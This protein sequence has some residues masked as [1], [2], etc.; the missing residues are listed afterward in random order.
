MAQKS[1]EELRAHKNEKPCIRK[2]FTVQIMRF[3]RLPVCI[4]VGRICH[5]WCNFYPGY[6]CWTT[7]IFGTLKGSSLKL[8][9]L[10]LTNS[11]SYG[12]TLQNVVN[13]V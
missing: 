6:T 12:N 2:S 11:F 13:A 5:V 7:I 4:P 9:S 10:P 1:S 3:L 8:N